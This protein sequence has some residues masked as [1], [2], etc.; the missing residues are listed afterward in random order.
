VDGCVPGAGLP[1]QIL[2]ALAFSAG[3][4]G[5]KAPELESGAWGNLRPQGRVLINAAVPLA[6][7]N[8]V[9]R[10]GVYAI[11]VRR[12]STPISRC[13]NITII[14]TAM[15]AYMSHGVIAP[16]P[17]SRDRIAT[18]GAA[19][20]PVSD[21][22]GE[23]LFCRPMMCHIDPNLSGDILEKT[24]AMLTAKS[25]ATHEN[26]ARVP[27]EGGT[28]IDACKEE[29]G[30]LSIPFTPVATSWQTPS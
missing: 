22:S 7:E 17:K 1:G 4:V 8:W 16:T 2:R 3:D 19:R 9:A 24:I 25:L 30:V 20:T 13:D 29:L 21:P 18:R 28:P 11:I 10:I 27:W 6:Q 12:G 14:G 23:A 15:L 26:P 5:R